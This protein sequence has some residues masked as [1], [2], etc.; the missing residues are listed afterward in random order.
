MRS[1]LKRPL[2]SCFSLFQ[3]L[4]N[5]NGYWPRE[6]FLQPEAAGVRPVPADSPHRLGRNV[7]VHEG[8]RLPLSK[9]VSWVIFLVVSHILCGVSSAIGN[10][11][12]KTLKWTNLPQV[13]A[14]MTSSKVSHVIL[15][16]KCVTGPAVKTE[17]RAKQKHV[18]V[19]ASYQRG[20]ASRIQLQLLPVKQYGGGWEN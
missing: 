15:S 1:S 3:D 16:R 19:P 5:G 10:C 20:H 18:Q 14:R 7:G 13:F 9:S 17:I 4:W 6:R 2:N 11:F 12:V 8:G